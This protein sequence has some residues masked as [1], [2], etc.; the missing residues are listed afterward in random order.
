VVGITRS[1]PFG[2]AL[3]FA[4]TLAVI[5][6]LTGCVL[7]RTLPSADGSS[8]QRSQMSDASIVQEKQKLDFP[9]NGGHQ[10][11]VVKSPLEV[12]HGQTATY[13]YS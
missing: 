4:G 8:T 13:V 3:V 12:H 9:M 2:V 5:T 10:V 11:K 1:K 7:P 6:Y